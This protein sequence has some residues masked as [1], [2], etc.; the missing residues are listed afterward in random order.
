[1]RYLKAVLALSIFP[2]AAFAGGSVFLFPPEAVSRMTAKGVEHIA[3]EARKV[4]CDGRSPRYSP[5]WTVH[6]GRPNTSGMAVDGAAENQAA[7][8]QSAPKWVAEDFF[9]EAATRGLLVPPLDY[10]PLPAGPFTHLSAAMYGTR[11]S[12]VVPVDEKQPRVQMLDLAALYK[13]FTFIRTP[14]GEKVDYDQAVNA[15]EWIWR[16]HLANSTK[17]KEAPQAD[18]TLLVEATLDMTDFCK[19]AVLAS[20]LMTK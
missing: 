2:G 12:I 9:L 16:E 7:W 6:V 20:D 1:M 19:N 10:K 8:L 5:K 13:T 11:A 4:L 3:E 17:T 14:A 18:G 15:K